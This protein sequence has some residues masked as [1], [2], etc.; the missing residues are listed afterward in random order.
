MERSITPFLDSARALKAKG[1]R[2]KLVMMDQTRK[3][4]RMVGNIEKAAMLD[5]FEDHTAGPWLVKFRRKD[6]YAS[7]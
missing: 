6:R 5:V 1:L 3:Y 4:P 2:G 7:Q